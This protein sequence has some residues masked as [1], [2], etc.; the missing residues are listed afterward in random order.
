MKRVSKKDVILEVCWQRAVDSTVELWSNPE[1]I[2]I[3]RQD[4]PIHRKFSALFDGICCHFVSV[5][6]FSQLMKI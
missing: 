1:I 5:G 6:Q 4:I 3:N 2:I